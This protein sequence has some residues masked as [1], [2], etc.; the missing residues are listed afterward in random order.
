MRILK[1]TEWDEVVWGK[2]KFKETIWNPW[3]ITPTWDMFLLLETWDFILLETWDKV[4][5]ENV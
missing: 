2:S 4:L 5:L 3:N 1:P